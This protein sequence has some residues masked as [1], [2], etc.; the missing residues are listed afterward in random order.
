MSTPRLL[1]TALLLLCLLA[2]AHAA[3][4]PKDFTYVSQAVPDAVLEVRYFTPHNFV[5]DRID[6]YLAPRVILTRQAAKAL[7]GVQADLK[8]FGL[9]VKVYD[10]Y[11]PQRAVDHFV[12]WG[13]DVDD[14][15]MKD[16]FYPDVD[17]RNLFKDG[18]IAKKSSH[19]RGS[20]VDLTIVD[21]ATGKDLD[22]GSPF[23]FFGKPSWPENQ[24]MS[25]QVRANRALLRELM[26]RH[27][28]KPLKEEWWHFT[29]ENEPFP[30]TYF[31]FP[32]Q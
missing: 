32:V 10:G 16:E 29:L 15:R 30:D 2:T 13:R 4:L 7:A 24:A 27:G 5:G 18:Y 26:A 9:S 8:L 1:S 28:F 20:T 23:D 12:R 22:M 14:T 31:N 19:S 6:G 17:K 21:T 25:A 3:D 11:R